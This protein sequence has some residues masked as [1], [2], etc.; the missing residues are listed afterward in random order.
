MN[1]FNL[2]PVFC[3]WKILVILILVAL[4]TRLTG[5]EVK[6]GIRSIY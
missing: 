6:T 5:W 3:Y 4:Y 2:N 1:A